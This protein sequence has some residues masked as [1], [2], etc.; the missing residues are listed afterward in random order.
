M[1]GEKQLRTGRPW[2]V[3]GVGVALVLLAGAAMGSGQYP[4]SPVPPDPT[5]GDSAG[6]SPG[7]AETD[8]LAR[9]RQAG[10]ARSLASDRQRRLIADTQELVD[11]ANELQAEVNK[12]SK[13]D[14]SLTVI[15]KA[16][17]IEKLAHDVRERERN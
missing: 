11:L 2:A 13:N 1:N 8:P 7:L 12:S 17:E 3:R 14:L 4:A 10:Q 6:H 16:G 9:S 5:I 15:R